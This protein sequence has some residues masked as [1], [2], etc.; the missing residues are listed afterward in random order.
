MWSPTP[1]GWP[2]AA[3]TTLTRITRGAGDVELGVEVELRYAGQPLRLEQSGPD[4]LLP[5]ALVGGTVA[6]ADR[7]V[8]PVAQMLG[9]VVIRHREQLDEWF[10]PGCLH[11]GDRLRRSG[12]AR[13]VGCAGEARPSSIPTWPRAERR[14]A[15]GYTTCLLA[16][17]RWDQP[18]GS[19][20]CRA[21]PWRIDRPAGHPRTRALG[22]LRQSRWESQCPGGGLPSSRDTGDHR[23]RPAPR[24]RWPV[25][26]RSAGGLGEASQGAP[27][28]VDPVERGKAKTIDLR[29]SDA[30]WRSA[31]SALHGLDGEFAA[32]VQLRSLGRVPLGSLTV[33]MPRTQK[34]RKLLD[35]GLRSVGRRLPE[36]LVSR[37]GASRV[38]RRLR[39]RRPG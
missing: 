28:P 13:V 9:D 26:R 15:A 3:H 18:H 39:S 34:V 20:R 35:R 6:D 33:V 38:V 22:A 8:E 5:R 31:T 17:T 1:S 14:C 2:T 16:S 7:T 25:A 12:T 19:I 10:L 32:E 27:D 37:L 30:A 29:R 11:A 21:G 4:W 24:V 23:R 36:P